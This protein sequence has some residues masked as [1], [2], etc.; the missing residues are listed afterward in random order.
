MFCSRLGLALLATASAGLA[1]VAGA[2]AGV[3]GGD[4][5]GAGSTLVGPLVAAW[6]P[7]YEAQTGTSISYLGGGSGAGIARITARVVDFGAS[8]AP[9][10]AYQ[11]SVCHG[12]VQIPWALTATA[13]S[14][15]VP[16]VPDLL[17]LS[18]PVVAGIYLGTITRWNDPAIEQLNPGV[19]LPDTKIVPV[20][21]RDASG[22]TYAFTE[23]LA[24]VSGE[25]R[26]RLGYGVSVNWP[27]G[28]NA[29]GNAGVA[30]AIAATA[31]A[32]GYVSDAYVLKNRLEKAALLN[33]AGRFQLPG[34]RNIAAAAAA[35]TS[36]PPG[37]RLSIV[38]PPKSQ[39]L[40]YPISTFTYAIVPTSSAKAAE[41]RKF[42]F[43][44]LTNGQSFGPKLIFAPIPKPVLRA[45]ERTLTLIR[46]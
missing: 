34:L 15:N 42:V 9:L 39:P 45:A 28:A 26:S 32:I 38:D 19:G 13:V 4:L 2:S 37:N 24:K 30:S 31:G 1:L 16:G 3:R 21:R 17:H 43:W 44:A 8:D 22:D 33:A 10:S 14:Y 5:T 7:A 36:V 25:F 6:A 41:L 29:L 27:T 12:C 23:Y 40:A 20:Y 18:G 46:G 35:I 11:L